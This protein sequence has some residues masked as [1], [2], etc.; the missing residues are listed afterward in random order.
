MNTLFITAI[1]AVGQTP[2]LL[3]ILFWILLILWAIG[4]VGYHDHPNFVRGGGLVLIILLAIL[5]YGVFGF[6]L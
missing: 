6:G 1:L 5:G 2:L 3:V 4:A